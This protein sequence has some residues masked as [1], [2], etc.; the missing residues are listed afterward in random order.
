MARNFFSLVP[1][2]EIALV[3]ATVKTI[4]Q[5]VAPANQIVVVQGVTITFDGT[6]NTAEPALV[7]ILRQTTAGT[8]TARNPLKKK[9]RSTALGTTGQVN[10]T[11]E[12]TAGD[13]LAS[14]HIHPQAGIDKPLSLPD[15]E[16]EMAGG[17]RLGI[18]VTAPANVN[19]TFTIDG[20]E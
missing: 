13:I 20:E 17:T 9:D 16:I 18:R 19:C 8:M 7:E 15:G 10:A 1:T 2:A 3:A 12:P 4:A 6:S 11:V 14:F 5:I